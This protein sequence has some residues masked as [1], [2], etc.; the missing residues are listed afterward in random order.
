MA[1]TDNFFEQ[2]K[3]KSRVKTLIV[4][5]FF[6]AY[7]PIINNSVGKK[8]YEIIYID[9]FCGPG[10]FDN[11]EPSTPLALLNT[12]DSFK[13]NDIR[14]KLKIVFN[15]ENKEYITKLTSLVS[16]HPV[17]TNLKYK[18]I[19][20]NKP[21]EEMDVKVYTSKNVPIF[22]FVDPWGYKGLSAEQTWELV[23][24]IGSDCVLFFNS[25]RFLMDLPKEDQRYHFESI[26]GEQ[27]LAAKE[28]V[29]DLRMGQKQKTQKIME[30]FS[31]NL[32]GIVENSNYRYKLYVLPFVFEADDKEK[33]S[34]HILFISKNHKAIIEMK[35]VM[36]KHGNA[37][38]NLLGFDSKDQLQISLFN[39]VNFVYNAIEDLITNFFRYN[40]S[41]LNQTWQ[42]AT[43][44]NVLDC[45]NMRSMYQVTPYSL[46]EVK[47]SIKILCKKGFVQITVPHGKRIKEDITND[48]LFKIKE[49]LLV[50]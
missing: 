15:D 43:L 7:F 16:N 23:K 3:D 41:R 30:L 19:I 25:N 29:K 24:N 34:H 46:D 22:S 45:Y 47:E 28:I 49:E 32:C 14:E 37:S 10:Q 4:T 35:K 12:V 6:K 26:F 38:N 27:L 39:R 44:L 21:A 36:I 13:S 20:T 8:A 48:R 33:T 17:T 5:D 18:P 2:Q 40:R 42:I 31:K 11:G 9:L 1:T 50:L